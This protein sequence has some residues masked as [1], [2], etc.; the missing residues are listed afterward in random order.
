MKVKELI[1]LLSK[2]DMDA[3]INV[4]VGD[5]NAYRKVLAKVVL[6]D[7]GTKEKNGMACMTYMSV[8]KIEQRQFVE[9]E[10]CEL[11]ITLYQN[12]YTDEFFEGLVI[13]QVNNGDKKA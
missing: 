3:E 4:V 13:S 11:T 10:E 7:D 9:S 5:C 1:S 8:G 2:N 6:E 12:Y